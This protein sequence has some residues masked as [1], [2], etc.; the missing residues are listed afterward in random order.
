[1]RHS[2]DVDLA[3]DH[4]ATLA[5]APA[6]PSKRAGDRLIGR[7]A[8]PRRGARSRFPRTAESS[9]AEL[10]IDSQRVAATAMQAESQAT[11][12]PAGETERR[13][14]PGL[15]WIRAVLPVG[16]GALAVLFFFAFAGCLR[17][18]RVPLGAD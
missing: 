7:A 17:H 9:M 1:L 4:A 6:P 10:D 13:D 12:F 15:R 14:R 3:C 16:L 2:G 8:S 5:C 18:I 11:P